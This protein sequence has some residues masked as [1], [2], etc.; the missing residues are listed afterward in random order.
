MSTE[1]STHTADAHAE[2]EHGAHPSEA[3]YLKI[4]LILGVLTAI[5]VGLYYRNLGDVNN[6]A[7]LVLAGTKFALVAA[8]FMHLKFDHKVLRRFFVG[9][10]ILAA[11]VYVAYLSTLGVFGGR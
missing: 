6:I 9:G 10:F 1:T 4:A 3:K 11:F 8:Y 2:G 5:E 7:L